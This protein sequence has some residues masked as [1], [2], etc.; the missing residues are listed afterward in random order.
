MATWHIE[1]EGNDG[2]LTYY[3]GAV[4]TPCGRGEAA[5]LPYLYEWVVQQAQTGDLVSMN[6]IA[7]VRQAVPHASLVLPA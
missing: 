4:R 1:Q 7:F 3:D 2:V 5:L 6:G